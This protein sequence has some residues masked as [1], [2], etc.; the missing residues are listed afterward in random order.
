MWG[1]GGKKM[2][3]TLLSKIKL[4]SRA[5]DLVLF[6]IP[7]HSLGGAASSALLFGF[8]EEDADASSGVSSDTHVYK[9]SLWYVIVES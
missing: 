6:S 5:V 9:I 4:I 3:V 8:G 7:T 2:E 1:Q